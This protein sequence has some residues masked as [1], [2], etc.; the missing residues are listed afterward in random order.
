MN[1]SI[2]LFV[3]ELMAALNAHDVDRAAA[4]YAPDYEELDVAQVAVP[5]GPA[6]IRRTLTHYLRAFPDLQLTLDDL[7]VDGHRAVLVWTLR[8]THH[9]TFMRIPPSGREVAVRGT[10]VL[11]IEDGKIRRGLRIWDLA[12][13]LRTLGLLPEL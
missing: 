9:G 11:T 6:G 1:E 3:D 13:L 8:G 12:G 2:R 5:V 7:I 4:F 10:S